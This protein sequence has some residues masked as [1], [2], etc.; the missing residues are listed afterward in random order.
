MDAGS[1]A[2]K[3]LYWMMSDKRITHVAG[4]ELQQPW[5]DASCF[6]M[7]HLRQTFAKNKFRMPKVTIVRSCMV[8]EIPELTY[9][10]SI[11]RIMWSNNFVF[12]KVQYF[13]SKKT[14]KSAPMPLLKGVTDLTSNAAFRFS[15]AF[16]GVT[17]IAVH[18][19]AGFSDEWNYTCFKPFNVSVTWG[20]TPCEVTI[21]RHIQQL[22]ITEEDMGHKTRY[23]LP[24]PNREELQLWDDN[25]IEWSQIIPTLYNA[26]AK[27]TFHT[28]NVVRKL[29]KD[30]TLVKYKPSTE[31]IDLSSDDECVQELS[32]EDAEAASSAS[33]L[34]QQMPSARFGKTEV[35]WPLLLTL[36]DS[37]WLSDPIMSAYQKLLE[38][39]FR[40]IMFRDL[41]TSVMRRSF[42]SRKIVVGYM[43]LGDCHWI[44]AKLDMTQNSATIADSLYATFQQEHDDVFARLQVLA[45]TAGHRRELQRFTI[46]VPDQRNSN[47]CGVFACLFQLY[48]A[49]S[50]SVHCA[51]LNAFSPSHC[52]I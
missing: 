16:S 22:D 17:F 47:D 39:Q 19:P 20:E 6:I 25:L 18:K 14:N 2:G 42:A 26:I 36:T 40:T 48:M 24:I 37:S 46:N 44:A 10:Y 7:A 45:N 30:A 5:Y 13:A 15:Q 1:E 33:K 21:I 8:A 41:K 32:F 27:E 43:N 31:C 11:A 51:V 35:H 28:D 12:D 4:V 49:Q 50:V 3:G 23:A 52:R 38:D 29:A 9:L 34:T